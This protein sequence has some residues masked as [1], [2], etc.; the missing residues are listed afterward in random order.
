M[1]G[2]PPLHIHHGIILLHRSRVCVLDKQ[3]SRHPLHYN[4][5]ITLLLLFI[6]SKFYIVPQWLHVIKSI[7][8]LADLV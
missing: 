6:E 5:N 8:A 3:Q 2:V 4:T 1:E 7:Y